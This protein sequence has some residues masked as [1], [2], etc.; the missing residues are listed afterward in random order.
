MNV[1]QCNS[2]LPSI[3]P[4]QATPKMTKRQRMLPKGIN[5]TPFLKLVAHK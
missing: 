4:A 2:S 5:I 1:D 3:P